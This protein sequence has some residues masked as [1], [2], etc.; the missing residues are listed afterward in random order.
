MVCNDGE[1]IEIR[2]R[3]T[4]G[5]AAQQTMESVQCEVFDAM[6]SMPS[7]IAASDVGMTE[8]RW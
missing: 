1:R 2:I 4:V 8:E 3:F 5:Y 6:K 7:R